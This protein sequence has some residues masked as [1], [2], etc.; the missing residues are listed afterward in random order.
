ML[1]S[2]VTGTY[3]RIALLRQMV[4]SVRRSLYRGLHYEFVV[5]DGGS[6]DGTIE[7]CQQ[8]ADIRL[9]AHGELRGAIRAFCDGA[10]MARGNYV[11]LCNDDIE[12][13]DSS[14]LRAIA[15]LETTP[16]AGAVAFADDR[17]AQGKAPG[18]AVQTQTY[19]KDGRAVHL[20][21]AQVG[22]FRRWL[23]DVCGWWGADDP[24]FVSH[25]YGG[26]NYLSARIAEFGYSVDAVEGV[27]VRDLVAK[28]G[29]REHNV[30]REDTLTKAGGGY[31]ARFPQPPL[32]LPA[33]AFDSPQSPDGGLRILYL[34]IFESQVYPHHPVQKRGLREALGKLGHL[35]EV[36]YLNQPYDLCEL[37]R[38]WQPDILFTQCQRDK[39]DLTEARNLQP[40]ML[41]LNW[42]GDVYLDAL[43]DR[44]S[45]AWMQRNVDV[46]LVVNA[47]ALPAYQAAKIKAA[48]W[49]CGHEPVNEDLDIEND[50]DVV[51]MGSLYKPPWLPEGHIPPR[52][53][54]V[55]L[56]T[57]LPNNDRV[58]LI[59]TGWVNYPAH[60]GNNTTYDFELSN[61]IR[62][63]A[64]IEVG[65]N[66]WMT[67]TGFV[68]N[69]M[70]DSLAS[71]GALM[72]HQHVP[73]LEKYTGLVAGTHYIEWT[74]FDDLRDKIAFWLNPKQDKK[75]EK[76]VKTAQAFVREHCSFDARVRE[77]F[78]VILPGV[79]S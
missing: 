43:I 64:K 51:F 13:I 67:D 76:M 28:D 62:R 56:L 9:I 44:D 38:N 47:A 63:R 75:R 53:E 57:S 32:L 7:W 65:D 26:D 45:L 61:A 20:P 35:V 8:Q 69:R 23:G 49:Q 77:L 54:L 41:V 5:V 48:Y 40:N 34:P 68:S 15:Y 25:T 52:V 42:N 36:D 66:Q 19:I 11:L 4:A 22:L 18:F 78:D 70:F 55:N 46:Q 1:L 17:P 60:N 24:N 72:L 79:L 6:T 21:Y 74:D 37:V 31:Y 73:E 10:Y 39:I 16:T 71:G 3:N 30:T 50:I 29:L 33:P 58:L 27:R 2:V 12:F 14:I 59:G